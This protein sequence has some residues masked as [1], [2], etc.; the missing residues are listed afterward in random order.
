MKTL[1][2]LRRIEWDI[3]ESRRCPSL[4]VPSAAADQPVEHLDPQ[5]VAEHTI[6][7]AAVAAGQASNVVFLGDSITQFFQQKAGASVWSSRIAPLG[8]ADLGVAG[9]TT[10]NLLWRLENGEL[11]GQPRV[12]VLM[13][14]TN[15]LGYLG[16]SVDQ[17]VAG[18]E[19]DIAAIHSISPGTEILLN[20]LFPRGLPTDQLRAEVLAVNAQLSNLAGSLGVIYSNPGANLVTA[21]GSL[22]PNVLT[23]L[24]HPNASGYEIWADG[25][26]NTIREMLST[27]TTT[28]PVATTT[29]PLASKPDTN[30]VV[31]ASPPSI[32]PASVSKTPT[33][34]PT[35][36]AASTLFDGPPSVSSTPSP[37][38]SVA[39]PSSNVVPS[40]SVGHAALLRVAQATPPAQ[41]T[42]D[43]SDDHLG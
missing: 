32:A 43:P 11:A 3:L 16:E 42:S 13:I 39:D 14:G 6:D 9:D 12:A 18:I 8:A 7:L 19:A 36:G 2:T 40:V 25:D 21:D 10:N 30:A 29:P 23:D 41:Q 17:T 27:S 22:G 33:I 38:T 1:R 34:S 28:A 31:Q 26:V 37:V 24:L 35:Q 15:N 20:G 4:T 5:S